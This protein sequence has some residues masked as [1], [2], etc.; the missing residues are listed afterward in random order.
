LTVINCFV[1]GF[2]CMLVN[3]S[4]ALFPRQ[5]RTFLLTFILIGVISVLELVTVIVDGTPVRLRPVNIMAK[6]PDLSALLPL[7]Q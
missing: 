2:M 6:Y 7:L 5:R 1:L 3:F 4:E